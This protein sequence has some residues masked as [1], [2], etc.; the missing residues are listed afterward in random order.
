MKLSKLP[1]YI[2]LA[3]VII[4]F[5]VCM[6]EGSWGGASLSLLLTL[7]WS[8]TMGFFMWALVHDGA[9]SLLIFL[10]LFAVLNF[11]LLNKVSA[12]LK[13]GSANGGNTEA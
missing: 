8:V 13:K 3:L 9:R 6:G 1:A 11:F 2:Y 4:A 7:P 12:R 5:I 10:I